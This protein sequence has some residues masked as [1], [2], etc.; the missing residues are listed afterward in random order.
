M[1]ST[2]AWHWPR[3]LSAIVPPPSPICNIRK[4]RSC[5]VRATEQRALRS[6]T[7]SY[8]VCRKAKPNRKL[9]PGQSGASTGAHAHGGHCEALAWTTPVLP[10]HCVLSATNGH[11]TCASESFHGR[12]TFEPRNCRKRERQ[13]GHASESDTSERA[14]TRTSA[15][16][17]STSS[18]EREAAVTELFAGDCRVRCRM[19]V[20]EELIRGT[21]AA[22][23][24]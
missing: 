13:V 20:G 6:V 10:P 17:H 9:Y 22:G 7:V 4:R 23:C 8:M 2:R 24:R 3:T 21:A 18:P 11:R 1:T 12:L 15:V 14:T 16:S 5:R 19:C